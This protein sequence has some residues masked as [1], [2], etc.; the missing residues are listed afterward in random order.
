[1]LTVYTDAVREELPSISFAGNDVSVMRISP[2]SPANGSQPWVNTQNLSAS[3]GP[4]QSPSTPG[5]SI[6]GTYRKRRF[7]SVPNAVPRG[8]INS[9][10]GREEPKNTAVVF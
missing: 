9:S 8:R 3:M 4:T 2:L 6:S 5:L 10:R 7:C 1:M